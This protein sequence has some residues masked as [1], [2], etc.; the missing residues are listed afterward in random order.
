MTAEPNSA[1]PLLT[2]QF[3]VPFHRIRAELVEPAIN[4]LLEEARARLASIAAAPEPRTFANTMAALDELTEPLDYA[5]GRGA[6]SGIRGHDAGTARRLQRGAAAG[7]RVLFGHSA[8][9]GAVARHQ[10]LSP[11][12]AEAGSL[13]GERRRFLHKTIETFRR[14]GADLD[15]AGKKRLEEHRRRADAAHDQ[16]RRERAGFHQRFRVRQP[17]TRRTWPGCRP[18]ALAA[19]RESA[20]RKGRAGWRFTLHAP[21]YFAV[22]TYLDSAAIRRQFY[23]AYTV[24]GTRGPWDNRPHHHS[25]SGT[26]RREGPAAGLP[27]FR[28]PRAGG[29]HGPQRRPRHGVS[30]GSQ[31]QDRGA[32]PAENRRTAGIPPYARRRRRAGSGALGRRVLRRESSA[33]RSTIST[34]RRCAPI[35]RWRAW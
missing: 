20:E 27:Q 8:G 13:Q 18:S 33:P 3:Q 16:V 4:S 5:M 23:D 11:P 2:V 30:G 31:E 14:H 7:Q 34:R 22:M 28:R 19:A 26:A 25:H 24:R 17:K 35:S 1:N 29:P 32:F 6:A 12:R 9:R 21:D 15:P 10:G